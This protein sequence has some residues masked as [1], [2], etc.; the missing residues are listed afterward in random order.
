M[1]RIIPPLVFLLTGCAS[2][3]VKQPVVDASACRDHFIEL[4]KTVANAGVRDQ[5]PTPIPGFPYLRVDR[6]L[7]SFADELDDPARFDAWVERLGHLDQLARHH[8]IANLS[9][10]NT[11]QLLTNTAD[12]RDTLIRTELSSEANRTLL[13]KQARVPDDY[14]ATWRVVGLYPITALFVKAGISRWHDDVHDTYALPLEKLPVFG[15]VR[16]LTAPPDPRLNPSDVASILAE[17]TKNPLGI[18]EPMPSHIERL[19]ATFA[20]QWSI[21]TVDDNDLPGAPTLTP[22]GPVVDTTRPTLY[23][24]ISHTRF[25]GQVL[26]QLNYII[27]FPS[28]PPSREGDI[29][30]GPFD[31]INFR[32]TL[33][34]NGRPLLYD[35]IHNCG[36][37]H[38]LFP[39]APLTFNEK[40]IKFW[41]ETPLVPQ[42]IESP[43]GVPVLHV[44]SRTHFINRL[45]FARIPEGEHYHWND[46]DTLRSLP[47]PSGEQ[48]SLF[49]KHG[50]I[51]ISKRPER[52]ILW[53]MGIR[54]PGAMRQWGHHPTAFIGRR[55]F[56]DPYLFDRLFV[57]PDEEAAP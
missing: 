57:L 37:Y 34:N 13:R 18:P 11:E 46:Y 15:M 56:D 10:T 51:E 16:N 7:A 4:D 52:F 45:Q 43:D 20:P 47:L 27:W 25:R 31:G 28:R 8:E 6:F 26:L 49:G 38:R 21:D 40:T 3:E 54:S 2:P 19:F 36:C 44:S 14:V 5:G 17:A 50:L 23:R 42:Q 24:R 30:A 55:H 48:H 33:G 39:V 12:C 32:V 9:G 53:P 22:A 1:K 35:T 41:S 29:Y